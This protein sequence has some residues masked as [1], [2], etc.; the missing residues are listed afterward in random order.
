MSTKNRLNVIDTCK[1]CSYFDDEYYDHKEVCTILKQKTPRLYTNRGYYLPIPNNCPLPDTTMPVFQR[2]SP[3]WDEPDKDGNMA[4]LITKE[5][6]D[7][8]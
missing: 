1:G 5:E 7:Q 2:E 8:L 3:S 6:H 4:I